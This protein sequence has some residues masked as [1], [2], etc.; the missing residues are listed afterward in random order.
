MVSKKVA[1]PKASVSAVKASATSLS[2]ASSIKRASFSPSNLR[3]DLFASLID[4]IDSQRLR[5]HDA[6]TGRLR[7]EY[8]FE[9]GLTCNSIAWN[10]VGGDD[11]K[12][13]RK[14]RKRTG[15]ELND[16]AS[17]KALVALAVSN[18]N[19]LLYS[20][21][22]NELVGT[23]ANGHVGAAYDFAFST[24]IESTTAWSCGADGKLVEWNWKSQ[25]ILRSVPLPE[26]SYTK[27]TSALPHLLLA[28]HN[29]LAVNASELD[30]SEAASFQAS[31]TP[32]HTIISAG[33]DLFV[34]SADSE[35][36]I[37]I[38]SISQNRL[39][40]AL[41]AQSDVRKI[42]LSG[43]G[44]STVLLAVTEDGAIELFSNPFVVEA[45][46]ETSS[47]R[48]KTT[49][50]SD[51]QIRI[52]RPNKAAVPAVDALLQNGEVVAAW[53]EGGAR[54]DFERVK[55]QDDDGKLTLS[56]ATEIVKAKA[57]GIGGGDNMNGAKDMGDVNFNQAQAVV[58]SGNALG[59][60]G[61]EDAE[62]A[63]EDE[64]S[65]DEDSPQE[66][67]PSFGEKFQALD[68]SATH[69]ER[70]LKAPTTETK[71]ALQPV[72][73][74]SLTTV[75]S[76]ALKTN[77]K[78]L[79]ESCFQ[80]TDSKVILA[81]IRRLESPLAVTLLEKL[82]ERIARKPGRAGSLGTWV[83]W[84]L[85]AHGG[86][87]V[88][89]PNLVKTLSTLH[90][91]LTTRAAALPRLLALQGRLDMLNAQLELRNSMRGA[92]E[93]GSTAAARER[94]E[95]VTYIEGQEDYSSDE[96]PEE[97]GMEGFTIDD[98]SF[99]KGK[100]GDSEGEGTD[101][102]D[103]ELIDDEENEEEDS[104]EE[105]SDEDG[106]LDTMAE[107]TDDDESDELEEDELDYSDIDDEDVVASDSEDGEVQLAKPKSKSSKA[108][109]TKK[110]K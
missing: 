58:V 76:Q 61:M 105:T 5:I 42:S 78:A 2:T 65:S 99:V 98:A 90:G 40:K 46:A 30:V 106:L 71:R 57:V 41:V 74:G 63:A 9:K 88:S 102:E 16:T 92:G 21:G 75:L 87:L 45:A 13:Q 104:D 1:P 60:V 97:V 12:K 93:Y 91:T 37:N 100:G 47:R 44:S 32:I 35:R 73:P 27:I 15:D 22:D 3:L 48:K 7:C 54:M 66:A 89:L 11:G 62:S 83:R 68:I 33:D 8:A 96:E 94:E 31:T 20:P 80:V 50:K 52:V 10:T 59:D 86:Y 34:T 24:D 26:Q 69:K 29:V 107:V 53:P 19:I 109:P 38:Y 77:D 95:Q 79:L 23:L 70:T 110:K 4:G 6:S 17:G 64:A 36:F 28:S 51:A 18:G 55:A 101:E 84:T 14:K 25:E 85:V 103:E 49:T 56:G 67:E 72:A 82:A 81:T 43:S 39:V 108:S